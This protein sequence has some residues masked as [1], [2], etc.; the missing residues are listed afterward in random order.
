M[1]TTRRLTPF[2]S[3]TT[4]LKHTAALAFLAAALSGCGGG[5]E[6]AQVGGMSK[7]AAQVQAQVAAA[8]VTMPGK[9][10]DYKIERIAG[11]VQ[12]THTSTALVT[13]L[14]SN[15]RVRFDDFTYGMDVEGNAGKAY[16]LYQ[17]AFARTPDVRG[18]SFW[19]DAMDKGWSL[20]AIA[21]EFV[22]SSEYRQVYGI[23]PSSEDIVNR[24]YRNVLGREGEYS[25]VTFWV[26]VL[27]DKKAT[28]AE[29]LA[30]FSESS[31]NQAGVQAAIDGGV[32]YREAG[33][34][35]VAVADAG[36]ARSS[37]VGTAVTLDASNS[38][39]RTDALTYAW[40]LTE[41]PAGSAAA[42]LNPTTAF[43]TFTPDQAGTYRLALSVNDGATSATA[44]THVSV[45]P[46]A[47]TFAPTEARYSR[48]MD[49]VITVST[50]PNALSIVDP[51]SSAIRTVTLPA[52]A[53]NFSLSPNG[54]LAIVLYDSVASLIDL[55]AATLVKSFATGG[56]H[57]DAF[58]TDTA[59]AYF[60]GQTG[61]QWVS[62]SIVYFNARTGEDISKP[63][64]NGQGRFYGTQYGIYAGLKN[65]VFLMS[66][67]LSPADLDFFTID[68]ATNAVIETGESPYHGD[69]SMS[70]PLYLSEN[71]DLLFTS[72]GNI[73]S[74]NNLR[75]A[76]ALSIPTG[77][78][79]ISLSNSTAKD[80]TV[81]LSGKHE[82]YPASTTL[83]PKYQIF[84][85]ALF[86]PAG[87]ANLPILDGKQTY[88][89]KIWHSANGRR[90][91]LVQQGSSTPQAA[92]VKYFVL[93]L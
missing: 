38:L 8:S 39:G 25:G 45:A 9:R 41:R 37:V 84:N 61:G 7:T 67:G 20:D 80:E 60:V 3:I 44:T 19:I 48:G 54:K 16:R 71:Q 83:P 5:T 12:L 85:S 35:Y 47:L 13:R 93:G 27:R 29:V 43:P 90:V 65:R 70:T 22:K 1:P 79:I 2:S 4:P 89:M 18:L 6:E 68:P 78:A 86:F 31:E 66:Q 72:T 58:V 50:N 73:F 59:I 40:T 26:G 46:P 88:G 57:T 63:I 76:G 87:S 82:W 51:F 69:Y 23:N 34:N 10:A 17:A 81:V 74:T 49:K 28:V 11:Q 92:G 64:T 21:Q 30:G 15:A 53:K 14:A 62:P 52:M 56:K 77:D 33:V 24:Y 36:P 75:Y 55:E 91:V 32:A 42:L